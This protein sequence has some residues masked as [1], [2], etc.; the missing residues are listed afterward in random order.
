MKRP[1]TPNV[2][3]RKNP[4]GERVYF[5]DYFDFEKNKRVR[6]VVGPRKAEADRRAAEIYQ[7]RKMST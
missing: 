6:E 4:S 3:S 5:V 7:Q 1:D 2:R